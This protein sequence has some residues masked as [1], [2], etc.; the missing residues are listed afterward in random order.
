[1]YAFPKNFIFFFLNSNYYKIYLDYVFSSP[2]WSQILSTS[3]YTQ[4]YNLSVLFQKPN[5]DKN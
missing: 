2:D 1:M 4:V 3:L 5:K